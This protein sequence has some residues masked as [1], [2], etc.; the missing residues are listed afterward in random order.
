MMLARNCLIAY[1]LE[2]DLGV[3]G[4]VKQAAAKGYRSMRS[5]I[6]L[7]ENGETRLYIPVDLG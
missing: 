4:A 7:S 5:F 6:K 3:I 1:A 2:K